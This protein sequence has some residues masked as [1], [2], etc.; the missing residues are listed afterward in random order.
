MRLPSPK[1]LNDLSQI[2]LRIAL[3]LPFW[4]SGLTKWDGVFELRDSA[5]ALFSDVFRLHVFG[6]TY[7]LPFPHQM[8]LASGTGE[9]LFPV[10]LAIGLGT[11]L[12][13]LG[14]L[15][16]TAVIQLV[17]PSGWANFHLIWA[18]CALAIA[19]HGPGRLSLDAEIA[20]RFGRKR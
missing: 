11:R 10:L 9:I 7:A 20:K 4:R 12:A 13:A 18:A 5:D 16:M 2:M 19:V 1:L 17:E 15:A 14:I 3:A 8:A 6:A